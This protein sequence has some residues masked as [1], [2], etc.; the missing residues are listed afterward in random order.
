MA[1]N[2]RI[3]RRLPTLLPVVFGGYAIVAGA[4]TLFG[5][6][7]KI[8]RLTDWDGNGI[9][10]FVNTALMATAG[11]AA[12]VLQNLGNQ[13]ATKYSRILGLIVAMIGLATLSEHLSGIDLGI[14]RVFVRDPWACARLR[15]L[16]DPVLRQRFLLPFWVLR[17]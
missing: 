4:S 1:L 16:G 9:S 15:L 8:S 6:Y 13:R 14:D 5:W 17:Y 12:L 2:P 11:G 10:M 7:A 3:R